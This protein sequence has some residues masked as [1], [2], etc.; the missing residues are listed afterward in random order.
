[1]DSFSKIWLGWNN[2]FGV[3]EVWNI[4]VLLGDQR[5]GTKWI[6]SLFGRGLFKPI[7]AGC[8]NSPSYTE[9]HLIIALSFFFSLILRGGKKKS[10]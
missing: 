9:A 3:F 1:L 6:F 5:K 2:Y 4:M 8:R 10:H 7:N